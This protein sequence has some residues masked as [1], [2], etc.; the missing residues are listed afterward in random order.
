MT[1]AATAPEQPAA[2]QRRGS[3]AHVRVVVAIAVVAALLA[4]ALTD[5]AP[6]SWPVVDA[7]WR[8]ALAAACALAASRS[9]RWTL[10]WGA[11]LTTAA[12]G[13]PFVVSSAVALVV[14][15]TMLVVGVRDRRLGAAVGAALALGALSLERPSAAGV[16]ALIALAALLPLLVSGDRRASRRVRRATRR[17]LAVLAVIVAL[18]V[19][20]A[21]L[22]GLQQRWSLQ[23]SIDRTR[24]AVDEAGADPDAAAQQFDAAAAD[25]RDIAGAASSWWLL[26]AR[27]TPV[28]GSHLAVAR[29]AATSGAELNEV[30]ATLSS[31]I[32][33]TGLRREEGG[34]DLAVLAEI[35]PDV[36]DAV[37]TIGASR[38]SVQEVRS[39]WLVSPV[40]SG[41]DDL[42]EELD[43]ADAT[44]RT[45]S[46]AIDRAPSLL[47]ADGPR[48][49][50]LLLGNPAETRDLGGHIGNW[51]EIVAQDGRLDIVE[52][53][54]PYDLAGPSTAPPLQMTPGAYPQSLVEMRPQYFPQNWGATADFPTVA[55]LAAELYPQVR[56]GAPLDGVLYAD[57]AA[58]AALLNFTGP[59]PVPGTDTVLTPDNAED[60]LTSGQYAAFADESQGSEVV[61]D[62]VDSVLRRF[63]QSQLP[64]P[65]RLADVLAPLVR[66][67]SLQFVTFDPDDQELLERAGLTGEVE[68]PGSGDLLA[69]LSRNANPSKIDPYV[70]R[71]TRY[72]ADW[73]PT[74]GRVD[75]RVTVTLTNAAPAT[76]L[77]ALIGN[78]V[79]GLPP[80]TDRMTLSILSPWE[81]IGATLDGDPLNVGTQQELR[82]VRRHNVLVDLAP[83]ETRVV[84]LTLTGTV[85]PG[86]PYLLQWVGQP[87][88]TDDTATFDIRVLHPDD[89]AHDE[90][91]LDGSSGQ[92]D[93]LMRI[94]A[95][96]A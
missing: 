74:T 84:Q 22:F 11:V 35:R 70:T 82:G 56:P 40:R 61:S 59:E 21:G 46:L 89:D 49:Y 14:A 65:D 83:G 79:P 78:P 10:V 50:L 64:R 42:L 15:V 67:G 51:A 95:R 80:G 62:M 54:G 60:F 5:A 85:G 6:T 17:G 23:S 63:G 27:V 39:P 81:A 69:V 92:E 34:V 91:I 2:D 24:A 20:T 93:L 71:S 57:P 36:D 16:T 33:R 13:V 45:A 86:A 76:G 72:S 44:A 31:S 66:R 7:L 41:V 32:G 9:R 96:P 58:F 87:T 73:D 68:R 28:V 19:V 29:T 43:S 4:V 77:P 30:A 88:T 90:Q 38:R 12:G 26:P 3:T 18:G 48:R 8:A 47:G 25:F 75:A 53:G 52:V 1:T 55:R 94:P 37:Q